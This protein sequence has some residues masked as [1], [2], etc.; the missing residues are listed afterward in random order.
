MYRLDQR[1]LHMSIL[2]GEFE[3]RPEI[4]G[5]RALAVVSVVLFHADLGVPGGF[6]GVDVFFVISGFLI[7][8]LIVKDLQQERFTLSHFWERRARRILPAAVTVTLSVLVAGWFYLLPLDYV[9]LGKSA[10]HQAGFIANIHFRN[11]IGYFNDATEK[12]PLLHTWSL[13]VEEQ[14]YMI[15]PLILLGLFRFPRLRRRR[16]ILALFL[17]AMLASLSLGQYDLNN[18]R[19]NAA[20]YLLHSRAWELLLG[21]SLAILPAKGLP[22]G[23]G[24]R[25]AGS[26]LGLAGILIPCLWYGSEAPFPGLAAIPP[27]LG[28]ALF[29]WSTGPKGARLPTLGRL[30]ATRPVVFI[31]LI[32]YS[33]YLW[34]W[35]ILA[36]AR[37]R[38]FDP[39]SLET[40]L[41][42]LGLAAILSVL[43]WRF[44][45]MPFRKRRLCASRKRI[46]IFA[47]SGLASMLAV[48]SL[49]ILSDGFPQRLPPQAR[50]Y[51]A[52]KGDRPVLEELPVEGILKGHLHPLGPR[53]PDR[54]PTVLLWGDSHALSAFP[55]FDALLKE[56]GLVGH[57][58]FHPAIAPVLGFTSRRF[59][60]NRCRAHNDAVCTYIESQR[61]P[62]VVLVARWSYYGRPENVGACLTPIETDLLAT[63]QHLVRK[64]V[65]PWILLQ[66]PEHSFDIPAELARSV[67]LNRSLDDRL[68]RPGTWNG[69][70][71]VDHAILRSLE[72]AGARLIDPRPRFLSADG[73]RYIVSSDGTALYSDGNH[74]SATGSLLMLLPLLRESLDLGPASNDARTNVRA[75]EPAADAGATSDP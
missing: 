15:V 11:S 33:L 40:R 32:S 8:S 62:V 25:E 73:T 16:T 53:D 4:D 23:N 59:R 56:K 24:V 36:I 68:T 57:A 13:A 55:A 46:F 34:H 20:F 26:C 38:S 61:I 14:F 75:Q 74:L 30:L 37:Y 1:C 17:V 22:N 42:L 67:L 58:V 21:C 31:G 52:A 28:A 64:G 48:G 65:H 6:V 19:P 27:C 35:P 72:A 54:P 66:V 60:D 44:V 51:A 39:L 45:E 12:M 18:Q 49:V 47:G 2:T 9:G 41:G 5:L 70:A 10:A 43:S 63:V 7:T 3:Y 50:L 29:I 69:L 71:G